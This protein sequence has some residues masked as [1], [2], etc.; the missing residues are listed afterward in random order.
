[1]ESIE[2]V[3]KNIPKTT[4]VCFGDSITEGVGS[5]TD[6]N[7]RWPDQFA[8]NLQE[9]RKYN[10]IAVANAGIGGNRICEQ[11]VYR[12]EHDVLEIK[13]YKIYNSTLWHK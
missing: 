8:S 3:S 11:G 2:V 12:F 7:N 6:G 5:T 10:N 4:I 13:G 9:N 1:M